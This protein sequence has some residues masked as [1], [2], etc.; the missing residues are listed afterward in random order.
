[1]DFETQHD[2]VH[3]R[4]KDSKAL[5]LGAR[6]RHQ[7]ASQLLRQCRKNSRC[8]TEA[9]R[10][11]MRAS[12]LW[13]HGEAVKIVMQRPEWTRCSVIPKGMLI[14]YG[15]LQGYNLTAEIKKLRKRIQ[16][17]KL[18]SGR[19]VLGG[20]DVSLNLLDNRIEGW[21]FHLYLLVEGPDDAELRGAITSAFPPEPTAPKPYCFAR[22][23]DY[24]EVIGYAYKAV[25]DRRS[26]WRGKGGELHTSDLPL[27]G[28]DL[29]E[30]LP[31]LAKHKVGARLVLSGVRRNGQRLVF[32]TRKDAGGPHQTG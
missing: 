10:V 13:W 8:E 31:F 18:L 14:P 22:V 16:R 6:L 25:F 28:Q 27:K 5:S 24:L 15:G 20:V 21:Q 2:A 1:V 11:C 12:R 29:R 23:E 17:S 4:R 9:C 26:A 32:T 30:L 7:N 3:W 19:V